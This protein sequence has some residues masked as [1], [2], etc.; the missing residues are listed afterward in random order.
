M[1][2]C[3][4]SVLSAR[5]RSIADLLFPRYCSVCG[6]R[7][8]GTEVYLCAPCLYTL[9]LVKHVSFTDNPLI[10]TFWGLLPAERGTAFFF[11]SKTS[12]YR[13]ILWELKYRRCP[14]IGV[15]M[16]RLAARQLAP[17]GFFDGIDVLVPVPLARSR[18][19]KRGYNQSEQI[20]RGIAAVT[21]LPVD[22]RSIS[23]A[24]RNTSQTRLRRL[25]RQTNVRGIFRLNTPEQLR[26]KHILLIDDVMTTG[27][28]LLSCGET[29][30]AL[31]GVKISI[32]ALAWTRE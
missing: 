22:T 10:R 24:V 9:P 12:A 26:G 6:K 31:P 25:E 18:Q 30:A 20:A 14:R 8:T 23:R 4:F 27:A 11:Y 28:T 29:L 19:R 21:R 2:F 7:L 17:A 16:G 13:H 15:F 5:F 1:S 32:L 3:S